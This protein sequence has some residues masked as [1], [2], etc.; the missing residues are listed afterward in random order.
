LHL[1][2]KSKDYGEALR[3]LQEIYI[4]IITEMQINLT[5]T[6]NVCDKIHSLKNRIWKSL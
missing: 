4:G 2:T 6:N 1:T 5:R 3:L